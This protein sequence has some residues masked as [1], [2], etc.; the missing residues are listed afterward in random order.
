VFNNLV[1]PRPIPNLNSPR[2]VRVGEDRVPAGT[3]SSYWVNFAKTATRTASNFPRGR[4]SRT[5][6]SRPTYSVE[7]AGIPGADVLNASDKAYEKLLT[8][9]IPGRE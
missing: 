3:I 1:A 4:G 9:L 8:S 7:A 2:G 6:T 5:A